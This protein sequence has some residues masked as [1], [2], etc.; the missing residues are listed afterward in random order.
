[1]RPE[2]EAN[3]DMEGTSDQPGDSWGGQSAN[4]PQRASTPN[5]KGLSIPEGLDNPQGLAPTELTSLPDESREL[6][7]WLAR[8]KM[9]TLEEMVQALNRKRDSIINTLEEL[10][11]KGY[12]KEMIIEGVKFYRVVFHAKPRRGPQG[13]GED[14]WNQL[15]LDAGEPQA[16]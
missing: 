7:T 10:L 4:A 6:I 9:A 16:K 12:V 1:M 14:L 5:A 13:L 3:S 11:P 2:A 15:D 8:R